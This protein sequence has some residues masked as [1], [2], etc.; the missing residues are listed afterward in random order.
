MLLS[1]LLWANAA[2]AINPLSEYNLVLTG[3]YNYQGGEV[4]GRTL[5]G[6][7]LNAAGQSPTFA[8]QVAVNPKIR[9]VEVVGNVTAQN[10]N[11]QSGHFV[12]RG[13]LN[14]AGNINHNGGGS[15]IQDPTLSIAAA[16][17][18]LQN[19]SATYALL[20]ANGTFTGAPFSFSLNYAGAGPVAVFNLS[21]AT[22]FANNNTLSLNVP[23]G[24]VVLINVTGT[25]IAVGG[26]VNLAGAGWA[27]VG[28]NKI[29]WNFPQATSINFNGIAMKGAVLAPFADTT[30]G[31]VF[32]GAFAAKSYTG[33]REFHLPLFNGSID[34]PLAVQSTTW[35]AIKHMMRA[36]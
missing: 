18:E 32:D 36:R 23:A 29:L 35:S 11:M 24:K 6:G 28:Y 27:A 19:S 7:N 21:A 26:G 31:A 33:A 20:S 34:P 9:T 4:E 22:L 1:G 12:Y 8:I 30:G 5:L 13:V 10:I 14:V 15:T 25:S 16:Q 2:P 3:D 17:A